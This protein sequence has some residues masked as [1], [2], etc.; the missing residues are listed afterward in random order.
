MIYYNQD[1]GKHISS[2]PENVIS[3][4]IVRNVHRQKSYDI[5]AQSISTYSC[6]VCPRERQ[7]YHS[8]RCLAAFKDNSCGF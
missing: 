6:S 1:G 7:A 2:M 4:E 3:D 8:D 5:L